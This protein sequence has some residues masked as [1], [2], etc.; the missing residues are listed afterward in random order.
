MVLHVFNVC[1][2]GSAR[3]PLTS[4]FQTELEI[5]THMLV[6]DIHHNALP[7]QEGTG[8]QHHSVSAAFYS[9]TTEC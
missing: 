2:V 1:S 7:G 6:V 4:P 8:G 9:L 3:Q 5:N